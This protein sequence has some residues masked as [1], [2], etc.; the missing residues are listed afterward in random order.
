MPTGYG[1]QPHV[2][3]SLVIGPS[4]RGAG[5]CVSRA[6]PKGPRQCTRWLGGAA[7]ARGP[8]GH[9]RINQTLLLLALLPVQKKAPG[10]AVSH[11]W[12][13]SGA[14]APAGIRVAASGAKR[15]LIY[16]KNTTRQL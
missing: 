13:K 2:R 7:I 9:A 11:C 15:R 16:L 8:K 6:L 10:Q 12:N 4:S 1:V 5:C 3:V 14:F